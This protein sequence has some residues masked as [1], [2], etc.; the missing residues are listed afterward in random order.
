MSAGTQATRDLC[1]AEH[2]DGLVVLTL[3][4]P[5]ARNA[6]DVPLLEAFAARLA[7]GKRAGA[8]VVLVRAEGPAFCAG[9]D[10]RSDDGTATG[11]PGLRRRLIEESLDLLGDYPAAVV[12]VQGA[13]IGAGWAI[14]AA[15]DITLASPTASFRFPE[16]PLGFPPPDSTVRI[17]EAAVGPARALRL[18][19]L[20]ERFVADDLARLGLVDV[21]PEDSLD[22]TARETAARLA[23][24]PLELLR[25]LKTGL[26]AGKRPPSIDRPASKG[27][28]EH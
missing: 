5:E 24:L 18:L 3:N 16:L 26:S 13:A 14:A 17:L 1:P 11:R 22:V 19:A 21:V 9:A 7:E 27:S 10:V 4:R 12:A 6:L 28:H 23:V 8:G 25:D 20:N 15:A 2:H